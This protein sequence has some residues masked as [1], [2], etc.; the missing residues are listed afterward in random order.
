MN[1]ECKQ[2][3]CHNGTILEK[4]GT[5]LLEPF[6]CPTCERNKK[7][8]LLE[9]TNEIQ[10]LAKKHNVEELLEPNQEDAQYEYQKY[11]D[12]VYTA[13]DILTALYEKSGMSNNPTFD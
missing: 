6:P 13:K 12:M 9:V 3:D 2:K 11:I 8:H 7:E 5:K 4:M 1:K 10:T